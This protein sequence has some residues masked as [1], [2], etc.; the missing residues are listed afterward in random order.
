MTLYMTITTVISKKSYI[1][2]KSHNHI[3]YKRILKDSKKNDIILY[4]N[5]I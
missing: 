4:I 5:S 1:G 3:L 2:Y